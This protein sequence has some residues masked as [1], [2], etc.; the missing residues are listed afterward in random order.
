M[1][2]LTSCEICEDCTTTTTQ[3]GVSTPI[4]TSTTEVCGRKDIKAVEGTTTATS[5][6]VTITTTTKCTR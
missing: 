1:V 5:G 6:S 4:G 2:A 3:N